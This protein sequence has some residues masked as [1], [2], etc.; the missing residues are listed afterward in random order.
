M[1]ANV[2]TTIIDEAEVTLPVP[3]TVNGL[4]TEMK[5]LLSVPCYECANQK[6][7]KNDELIGKRCDHL[8]SNSTRIGF[9]EQLIRGEGN[10]AHPHDKV[11]IDTN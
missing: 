10:F 9:A 7:I 5:N 8:F 3:E 6:T 4:M 11:P 2:S 1:P